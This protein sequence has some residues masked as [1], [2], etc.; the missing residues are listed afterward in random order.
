MQLEKSFKA[1]SPAK[2]S[3]KPFLH[4][5]EEQIS[6]EAKCLAKLCLRETMNRIISLI[7]EEE[8]QN[9]GTKQILKIIIKE[10]FSLIKNNMK[11]YIKKKKHTV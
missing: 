7:F 2:S 3:G 9:K 5:N 1:M 10:K 6:I 8:M 4:K 11:S